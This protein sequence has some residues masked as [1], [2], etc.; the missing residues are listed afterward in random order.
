M[1]L[2]RAGTM[3]GRVDAP[4]E[5]EEQQERISL[6]GLRL[7]KTHRDVP[8]LP[9]AA[10]LEKFNPLETLQDIPARSDRIGALE[11]GML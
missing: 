5:Q 4:G 6:V 1:K 3:Q 2:D 10:L 11:T 8:F 9:L 7:A